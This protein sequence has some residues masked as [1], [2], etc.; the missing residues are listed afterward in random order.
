VVKY[1]TND[2]PS[3]MQKRATHT[4]TQSLQCHATIKASAQGKQEG[5][6][7]GLSNGKVSIHDCDM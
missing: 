5:V 7:K 4:Q 2:I 1:K 3:Q 6:G